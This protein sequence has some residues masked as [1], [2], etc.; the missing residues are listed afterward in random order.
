[1]LYKTFYDES[2]K[3]YCILE[4]DSDLIV[5]YKDDEIESKAI[6]RNLNLGGGFDGRTPS[7]F[8]NDMEISNVD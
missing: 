2:T 6:C 5:S 1:M 3:K 8:F 7:F 4:I